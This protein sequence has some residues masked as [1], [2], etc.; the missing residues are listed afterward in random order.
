MNKLY[1]LVILMLLILQL[2]AQPES[3]FTKKVS[4]K[5]IPT[6]SQ[7]YVFHDDSLKL[8]IKNL[9]EYQ[10]KFTA[11]QGDQPNF[12]FKKGK[13]FIWFQFKNQLNNEIQYYL[14]IRNPILDEIKIY[15]IHGNGKID[16][17]IVL[18]DRSSFK[19]RYVNAR[20]F[21]F[22]VKHSAGENIHYLIS[23][24]N[25]GE[26]CQVPIRLVTAQYFN[27]EIN[28]DQLVFGVYYGLLIFTLIFNF[29][30]LL[31]IRERENLWYFL[32]VLFLFLLQLSLNGHGF[33]FLWPDSIYLS[34]HGNPI[35]A[36]LS[37][38]FLLRFI[39]KFFDICHLLPKFK[40]PLNILTV[41]LFINGV[42]AMIESDF[43]FQYSV[44]SINILALILNVLIIPISFLAYIKKAPYAKYLIIAFGALITSVFVFLL[45]NFG[46]I[47]ES[48]ITEYSLP[49]GSSF[50]VLLLSFVI[51]VKFKN[52]KDN[53]LNNLLKI[54]EMKTQANIVLEQQVAE[55]TKELKEKNEEVISS[56]RYASRIQD[57]I[58]PN[59]NLI[60]E[61]FEE[62]FVIFFPKDIVSG[63]FYWYYEID[64]HRSLICVADCTGHGVPGALMSMLGNSLFN[65]A[66]NGK[67]LTLP[68]E[69]LD[70]V[71][72]GIIKSLE[73]K[74]I[75]SNQKDGMDATLVLIDQLVGKVYCAAANNSLIY[76]L[77]GIEIEELKADKQPIG[78]HVREIPFSL[79]EIEIKAG[80]EIYLSSDGFGDQFGGEHMK[81]LKKAQFKKWLAEIYPQNMPAKKEFLTRAFFDW[82]GNYEQTDDVCVIGIRF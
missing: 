73:Q 59:E 46:I 11:Y 41:L 47:P 31:L 64:A 65:A 16:S 82:K 56:I 5:V 27:D 35:F 66:V 69:I 9:A 24:E 22:P 77:D 40:L 1:G 33:Q 43:S 37:V 14:E 68:N 76:T 42:F 58:I 81:K 26:Q 28:V 18:G 61:R 32:Y 72:Q 21:Y 29:F 60:K 80:L 54:N 2:F 19:N 50:E 4:F 53:A 13:F 52:F 12:G 3:T 39:M 7:Y 62:S 74:G 78:K 23:I 57:A 20:N 55:R 67:E 79:Q 71:R 36:S 45:R 44:L 10:S 38:L 8:S 17:S 70:D 34:N 49:I 51:V 63:D 48:F 25:Y 75:D 30:L 15:G 6:Q